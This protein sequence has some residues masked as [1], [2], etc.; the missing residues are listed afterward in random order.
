MDENRRSFLKKA[1]AVG[2]GSVAMGFAG[3][4]EASAQ[5]KNAKKAKSDKSDKSNKSEGIRVGLIGAGSRSQEHV[6][7][8]MF[9]GGTITAIC[10]IQ[11]RSIQRTKK[12]ISDNGGKEPKVYTGHDRAFEEMLEKEQFD[13]VIICSPWE[14]H[15]PMSLASMKA[16]VKYVGVEV[17]AANTL[18]ECWDLV[19]VSEQTGSQLMIMENVC[20]RPD[21]MSV[22]NMVRTDLFGELLHCRAG[23]EHDLRDVKFNDGNNYNYKKGGPLYFGEQAF[24]EAQWRTQHSIYRN[25]DLYPTHGVGPVAVYLD[26]NRGNRFLSLSAMGTQSA[27]LHKFI[28]DNGGPNHPYAKIKFNCG[29]IVTSM[30][31]CANGQ[32]VIITHDTN[33]PRPYSLGFRVQGTEGLWYDDGNTI[34]VE[35]KSQPHR[36]DDSQKWIDEYDHKLWRENREKAKNAGHGGMDFVMMTDFFDAIK[37]NKPV[38]LD[39]YDAA[40]WSAISALSESSIAQGGALV[41]FPDFTRGQWIKRKPSFALDDKFPIRKTTF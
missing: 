30:I 20:Y 24:A 22:I 19:N 31:K 37:N 12:L 38:P 33:S 2:L 14:W 28:V 16:G 25:G 40:A 35:G 39:A 8:I 21:V 4:G 3:A 6:R 7:N 27:G 34:Y 18:E 10:D 23:Y 36:W 9:L 29:D 1:T 5:S 17:S 32:T 41:D 11:D 13:A 26:I 15:V